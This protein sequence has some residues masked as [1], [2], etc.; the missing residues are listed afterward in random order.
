MSVCLLAFFVLNG[1]I[2]EIKDRILNGSQITN[3]EA[4]S[5]I[6]L[7]KKEELYAAADEIRLHYRGNFM[8][9]CAIVSAKS[10][11]CSQ[12]C[13]WC[14]QSV[15]HNTNVEEYELIDQ[16]EAERI[17]QENAKQGVYRFSLVTSGRAI[18]NSNLNQL[19]N[20][21]ENIGKKTPIHLCAS[22]GLLSKAQLGRLK[23]AGVEHYHCNIETAP[24]FFPEVCTSHTIE[25]KIAT[26][27]SAQELGMKICSGGIL[28]MGESMEQR[29]EMAFALKALNIDSIPLNI[30]MPVEGTKLQNAQ[31]LSD[32]DI[33]TTFAIF[34]FINPQADIRLAGGRSRISHIQNQA[35]RTGVSAALVGDYLTT[36]GT[37]VSQ[38]KKIFSEAGFSLD[39]ELI[40]QQKR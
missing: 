29:V 23:Q 7:D 20:V 5:L 9:M 13:K 39:H 10:G 6:K 18:S 36:V 15:F 33:L 38:D 24:S 27:K 22:M 35:L 37:N 34:R 25:E 31:P 1:M 2:Q 26:I 28:G 19:C 12:N 32:E 3:E 17:A 30:L 40:E 14:S 11:R 21:Y 16:A 4:L 8:E